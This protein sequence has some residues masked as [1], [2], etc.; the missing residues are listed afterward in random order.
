MKGKKTYEVIRIEIQ[1]LRSKIKLINAI[2]KNEAKMFL[3]IESE[4]SIGMKAMY[5]TSVVKIKK[6][7]VEIGKL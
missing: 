3:N 6:R 7:Y 2:I 5:K 4:L 1:L